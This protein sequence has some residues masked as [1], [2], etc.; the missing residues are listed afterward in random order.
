MRNQATILVAV[1]QPFCAARDG[2]IRV[3]T[4]LIRHYK[5][6]LATW[7]ECLGCS[8]DVAA[9]AGVRGARRSIRQSR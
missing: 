5:Y 6:S 7:S 2:I 1:M 3:K 8:R 9:A 4:A